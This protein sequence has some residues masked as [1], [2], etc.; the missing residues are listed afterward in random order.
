MASEAIGSFRD[1][2]VVNDED[3]AEQWVHI[4]LLIS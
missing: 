3:I 1:F 2:V 4:N